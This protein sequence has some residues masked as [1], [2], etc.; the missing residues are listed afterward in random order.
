M[1]PEMA[2]DELAARIRERADW[3]QPRL[4]LA[5]SIGMPLSKDRAAEV[6]FDAV[7]TKPVRH[8]QL[9]DCLTSLV[10]AETPIELV[11]APL[12]IEVRGEVD[13]PPRP[14]RARVLLAEDNEVNTL[15]VCTLMDAFGVS[16]VC[17]VN[18]EEAVEEVRNQ[19]FDLILRVM[20]RPVL[21]GLEATRRIRAMGGLGASVPIVAM[22]ANAMQSAQDACRE[23]GMNGYVS[24]PIDPNAFLETIAGYLPVDVA[25][26]VADDGDGADLPPASPSIIVRAQG[27]GS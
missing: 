23:A 13:E 16:V 8:Q 2:G 21:D 11:E 25:D 14:S 10:A 5:S 17:A 4:V 24:K 18:G 6:G 19:R 20:Q 1:M 9:V 7:L 15:L 27:V 22:T 12:A 3:P 26:D